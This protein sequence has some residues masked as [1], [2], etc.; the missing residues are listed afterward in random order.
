M[1][2]TTQRR[3]RHRSRWAAGALAVGLVVLV[4]CATTIDGRA[5]AGGTAPTTSAASTG[6]GDPGTS[7]TGD[8]SDATDPS[9][10]SDASDA[11]DPTSTDATGSTGSTGSTASST[12]GSS[13]STSSTAGPTSDDDD[14]T[15][16]TS[17]SSTTTPT[18]STTFTGNPDNLPLTPAGTA[19][20][21]GQSALLP[22]SYADAQAVVEVSGLTVTKGSEAD[23]ATL[24]MDVSDAQGEE[25]WYLRM[26]LTQKSEGDLTYTSFQDDLWAY[27]A[28]D[29][30]ILTAYPDDDANALCPLSY[31]PE[32]FGVGK[33]YD[34]CVVLSVNIG[35]TVDRI[36]FEGGFEPDDPYV[37]NPV[38]WKG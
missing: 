4:G 3:M 37:E 29:D 6:T 10:T 31:A 17:T 28:D 20:T 13:S 11:S 18:D 12:G 26:T 30:Y 36:Q 21:Y 7:G 25:P 38:V 35:E 5:V 23:W 33:S 9:D 34:A 27:S 8:P 19:L 2:E 1:D 14:P 15:T 24:G 22:V 32:D 16:G